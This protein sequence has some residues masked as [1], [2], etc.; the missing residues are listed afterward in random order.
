MNFQCPHYEF[1]GHDQANWEERS[2][3]ATLEKLADTFKEVVPA[4]KDL[5]NGFEIKV[6]N[7]LCRLKRES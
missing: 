3:V 1:K 5:L 6:K 7:G 2:E 4:L